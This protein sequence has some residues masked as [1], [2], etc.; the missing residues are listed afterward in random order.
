MGDISTKDKAMIEYFIVFLYDRTCQHK[1]IKQCWKYLFTKMN[2]MIGNCLPTL[3][4]LLQYFCRKVLQ[5]NIW[6][7]SMAPEESKTNMADSEGWTAENGEIH[8]IWTMLPKAKACK[9]LKH[10]SYKGLCPK[11]MQN[12]RSYIYVKFFFF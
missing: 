6:S 10:Y 5:L 9:E 1:T 3:N 4:A 12:L 8:P 2:C 11:L 7:H